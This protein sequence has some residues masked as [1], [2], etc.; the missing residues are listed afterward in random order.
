MAPTFVTNGDESVDGGI[1]WQD[2]GEGKE[3]FLNSLS[4]WQKDHPY[5][6]G[7]QIKAN[8]RSYKAR[9][10]GR[11]ATADTEPAWKIG[12]KT[13]D[14]GNKTSGGEIEWNDLGLGISNPNIPAACRNISPSRPLLMDQI[15]VVAI[16]TTAIPR[17]TGDRF[18]LLN[19]NITNQQ[20][21]SLNPTP[22][23]PS[24]AAGT[25]SGAETSTLFFGGTKELA[26]SYFITWPNQ[27]P[28]D[29]IPTV[30][31]NLVYTPVAPALP[32]ARNTFYPAGSIVIPSDPTN[33]N[34]HYY[35]AVNS[36]ISSSEPPMFQD[37]VTK[38][39]EVPNDGTGLS[40]TDMGSTPPAT[41]PLAWAPG[42]TYGIGE[43]VIPPP[44]KVTGHYYR[45]EH[46]GKANAGPPPFSING[47]PFNDGPDLIWR[48]MGLS[49]LNPAPSK[50]TAN[51]AYAR[52]AQVIP[53]PVNGHYYQALMAAGVT[54]PNAPPF[55]VDGTSVSETKGIAYIDAGTT[56]PTGA[57]LKA[58]A[59]NTA[60]FL[61]DAIEDATTGHYYSVI[62]P[63]ISGSVRPQFKAPVP[64]TVP[65]SDNQPIV[66]QDFGA[67]LPSSISAGTPPS[68]QNVNLLT[69]TYPQ[70]HAL[71]R[72]NLA[73]GV[74][75][76][77]IR[78]RS[79]AN[80]NASTAT[81]PNWTT[82][83]NNLTVDPILA[84]TLYIKPMDAE[85]R[86]QKSDFIPEPTLG[87]SLASPTTNFYV[88]FS[89]ELFVRNLQLTY[90]LSLARTSILQP[91]SY[92]TSGTSP[93]TQQA[94]LK[95]AFVGISFNITG[96]ISSLAR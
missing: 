1:H 9:L 36:G 53:D 17:E 26:K 41:T 55:P 34:G 25:A 95:G 40:W 83:K 39:P 68:D 48:D 91:A 27:L 67:T 11:N 70:V 42:H 92:Q 19:L 29:T 2:M 88:G 51:T 74:V 85:R 75:M 47:Q 10:V 28:G 37:Y 5:S 14:I 49:T 20:G 32:W 84:V 57:K 61:N 16:D 15:L 56:L 64:A 93:V 24:L 79:F 43:L 18:K 62:Q 60:F 94:F 22:I 52:G 45:A 87:F 12:D 58:W 21:A 82:I 80:L 81:T 65:G 77:S 78:S 8:G 7:D 31:V 6:D 46:A 44:D 54:G 30:S 33:T 69:Y 50:W 90:G 59:A 35:L 96:F 86:Y 4:S 3:I 76:S 72:F 38:V 13:H 63:G 89:S 71:S 73:A 66:W 23:R